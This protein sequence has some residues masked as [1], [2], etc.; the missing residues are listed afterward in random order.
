MPQQNIT[1]GGRQAAR[2]F[3]DIGADWIILIHY[4]SWDHFTQHED[5]LR[6]EF[7]TEGVL[8]RVKWMKKGNVVKVIETES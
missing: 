8:D 1:M 4:E 6:I 7:K 3:R 2:L 5:A